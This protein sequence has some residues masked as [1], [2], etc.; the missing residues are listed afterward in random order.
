MFYL[1]L[2]SRESLEEQGVDENNKKDLK[3][4]CPYDELREKEETRHKKSPFCSYT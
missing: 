1:H 4:M 3:E 2:Q